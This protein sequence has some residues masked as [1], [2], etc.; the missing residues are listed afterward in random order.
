MKAFTKTLMASFIIIGIFSGVAL[1]KEKSGACVKSVVV[2]A[3]ASCPVDGEVTVAVKVNVKIG[4]NIE[5]KLMEQDIGRDDLIGQ[6]TL[7]RSYTDMTDWSETVY[8]T[9][10]PRKFEIGKY[11][12]IYAKAGD[13]RSSTVKIRLVKS[14]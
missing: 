1:S 9:F 5:V 11:V 2:T 14:K 6:E 4:A 8:F 10:K 7:T 12:E 3:P 13:A